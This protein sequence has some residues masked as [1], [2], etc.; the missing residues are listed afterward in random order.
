MVLED[1]CIVGENNSYLKISERINREDRI[2]FFKKYGIDFTLYS[3]SCYGAVDKI[4]G[5]FSQYHLDQNK[6]N[7]GKY[8]QIEKLFEKLTNDNRYNFSFQIYFKYSA[9]VKSL[10]RCL[11]GSYNPGIPERMKNKDLTELKKYFK[12]VELE[13]RYTY[14]GGFGSDGYLWKVDF[15]SIKK[16]AVEKY[17]DEEIIHSFEWGETYQLVEDFY[18][19]CKGIKAGTIFK[20][21][22]LGSGWDNH[23]QFEIISGFYKL[24]KDASL[25]EYSKN[26]G[27][28][29]VEPTIF[30]YDPY[31]IQM[32]NVKK[33]NFP[34]PLDNSIKEFYQKKYKKRKNK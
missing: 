18:Y 22:N 10:N 29:N 24:T 23:R 32:P 9:N 17:L 15:D 16:K 13:G 33:V 1:K 26:P 30:T 11:D 25:T 31:G 20:V 27:D 8:P 28:G 5:S 2:P 6:V 4:I 19:G 21:L 14:G 12:I 34:I 3:D 7:K